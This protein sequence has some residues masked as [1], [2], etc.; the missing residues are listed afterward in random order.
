MHDAQGWDPLQAALPDGP[1]F[2]A[3]FVLP[4]FNDAAPAL[5]LLGELRA[6][7][8]GLVGPG[9]A[10][11]LL[12]DDGSLEP[13]VPATQG[14]LKVGVL[15]LR[16]NLGHQRAIATGLAF[17]ARWVRPD[18]VV[19]VMDADGEDRPEDAARLLRET[20]ARPDTIVVA[21]RAHRTEG[22]GFRA[23][24]WIYRALFRLLTGQPIRHGNFSA[25]PG[26][27]AARLAYTPGLWNHYAAVLH[28]SRLPIHG[29]ESTRGRRYAGES[30]MNAISLVLHG[31]SAVS[32]HIEVVA[33]RLML[34][35]LSL[36][37]LALLA[38][39]AVV[40]TRLLTPYAVPG[41]ASVLTALFAIL[42]ALG[43][44]MS[45]HLIFVILAGR[46]RRPM[47]PALDAAALVE[48][49]TVR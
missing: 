20:R 32:V 40:G 10:L 44:M 5:R 38:G 30:R 18:A 34:A 31:L 19:V 33:V 11:A 17:V 42:A 28:G 7:L 23:G 46:E 14:T 4:V 15:R 48:S 29:L 45:V 43:L 13:V 21:N 37:G 49:F 22:P 25:M 39:A 36:S 6:A 8:D 2:D 16:A 47:V 3:V 41:W 24:Y 9:K 27:F 35:A 1:T 12:V 26:A